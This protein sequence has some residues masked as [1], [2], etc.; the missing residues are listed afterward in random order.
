MQV[1]N[2][3]RL[4]YV[5]PMCVCLYVCTYVFVCMRVCVCMLM[6]MRVCE[7][8]RERKRRALV[9]AHK[10][11]TGNASLRTLMI[12]VISITLQQSI[13]STVFISITFS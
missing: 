12:D 6:F 7:R 10:M 8:E 1:D 3:A 11:C 2:I 9:L 13:Y 5:R 4:L